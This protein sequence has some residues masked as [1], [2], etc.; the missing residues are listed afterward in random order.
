MCCICAGSCNHIGNHTYCA[1]HGGSPMLSPGWTTNTTALPPMRAPAFGFR[2]VP[3]D[4]DP[5]CFCRPASYE[6]FDSTNRPPHDEC[7]NCGVRRVSQES[8]ER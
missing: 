3:A 1:A 2:F 7:C 4:C 6:S 8:V 5:H